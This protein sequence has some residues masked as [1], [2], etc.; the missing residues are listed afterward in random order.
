[1]P[2]P[3]PVHCPFAG[4]TTNSSTPFENVDRPVAMGRVV[5]RKRATLKGK[6]QAA[7]AGSPAGDAGSADEQQRQTETVHRR[8]VHLFAQP[9]ILAFHVVRFVAFQ[10]WLL[11]SLVYRVGSTVV[12]NRAQTDA[13][14]AVLQTAATGETAIRRYDDR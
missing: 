9:V 12:A 6:Q 1:M 8:N 4:R 11:L 14:A 5:G 7:A 13:D 10:L 3:R 2:Q